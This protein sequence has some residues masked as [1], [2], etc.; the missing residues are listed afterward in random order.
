[1]ATIRYTH[2]YNLLN[3]FFIGWG[4]GLLGSIGLTSA[5]ISVI[6]PTW[7]SISSS[8]P[9]GIKTP[10]EWIACIG[11][12]AGC[13]YLLVKAI[14]VP[15]SP[16]P[17]WL[18][19]RLSLF[20][21]ATWQDAKDT[22]FL[23]E[24]DGS[25]K[26]YPFTALR[27]VPR[28]F[29]REVLHEFAE[30]ILYGRTGIPRPRPQTA[31]QSPPPQRPSAAP[32]PPAEDPRIAGARKV[33]GVNSQASAEEVKKAYRQLIK[34]YHPDVY[35]KSQPELQHFAHEKAKELNEAYETL[36]KTKNGYASHM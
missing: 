2:G 9:S 15:L 1:M 25:G 18:Y 22:S 35:A 7:E 11:I 24:G 33:L 12:W 16:L 31:P 8:L 6:E 14:I 28:Q 20:V 26:W 19:L 36:N 27:K 10:I 3:Q 29:R 30:Q 34:K 4:V 5:V 32:A 13:L 17:T 21:P 23:F